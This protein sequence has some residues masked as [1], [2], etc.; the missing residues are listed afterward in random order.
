[1]CNLFAMLHYF[2]LRY[3]H[4]LYISCD[5][6]ALRYFCYVKEEHLFFQK[7]TATDHSTHPG[8]EL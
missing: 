4:T 5:H 2:F 8:I 3:A 1:M 6:A 7:L